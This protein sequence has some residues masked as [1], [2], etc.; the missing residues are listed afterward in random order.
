MKQKTGL[1]SLFI[2]VTISISVLEN[3]ESMDW[4]VLL[5]EYDLE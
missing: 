2:F 4:K 1:L 5:S 3:T